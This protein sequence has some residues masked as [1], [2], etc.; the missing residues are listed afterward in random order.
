M[1]ACVPNPLPIRDLDWPSLI[2]VLGKANRA[3]ASFGGILY[4]IPNP[5]VLLSPMTT[6]EAVVSSRIEGTQAD[7]EDVLKFEA[8]EPVAE[9]SRREDIHE[10]VNYRKALRRANE[11]LNEKPF[12]LNTLLELH[13][14][15]LEGVR[16]FDKSPGHFRTTQN[17]IGADGTPIE[18]A[19]YIPPSPTILMEH[20]YA[21]ENYYHSDEPDPLVQL[22]IIHAQFEVLHPFKDGNG[23]IGRMIIP[24]FLFEKKLLNHP[25]F[26]L[27]AYF[28][29]HL[30]EYIAHLRA[31]GQPG[32]WNAWVKFFL[33]AIVVQAELNAN[34]ARAIQDLYDRLKKQVL[35]LTH[36]QYAVPLLDRMFDRPINRSSDFIGQPDMP[37][38]PMIMNM[39]TRFKAAGILKTVRE[40]AGRRAQILALAELINLCEGRNVI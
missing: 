2:S 3:V 39:L 36:S 15:L 1:Q 40:G 16:G 11:L 22:A 10:I 13:A 7:F 34:R 25:S 18:Q 23:R 24:M 4:G 6:Q 30:D 21:W 38:T 5:A 29:A 12:C 20:L 31:L 19:K 37:S 28:D 8:G 26:Y 9:E 17:W 14:I 32:S 33:N 35:E 27:S